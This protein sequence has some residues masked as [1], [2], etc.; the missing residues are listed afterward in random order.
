MLRSRPLRPKPRPK[1]DRSAE[2]AS[3]S[4]DSMH[5]G[6][7]MGRTTEAITPVPKA[8]PVSDESYRR[9]VASLPCAHCGIEGYSQA[10]H[11]DEGKGLAMKSS[12]ETCF[13][14]CADRPGRRGC[15]S[16]IGAS[17]MFTKWQRRELEQRYAEKTR[18]QLEPA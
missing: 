6:V 1:R 2:F 14:L 3:F 17:G 12:D 16:L 11:A 5:K 18:Q 10:A 15:H 8:Q 13:P 4:L 7:V 9:W